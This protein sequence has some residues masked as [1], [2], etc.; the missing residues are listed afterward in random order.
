[1]CPFSSLYPLRR[2]RGRLSLVIKQAAKTS[3]QGNSNIY[4]MYKKKINEEKKK[5]CHLVPEVV[6]DLPLKEGWLKEAAKQKTGESSITEPINSCTG[7]FHTI[8]VGK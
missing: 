3:K 1:M 6:T 7:E 5:T 4:S 2:G 8:F